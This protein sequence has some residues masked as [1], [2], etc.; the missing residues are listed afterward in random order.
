MT[1]FD[2]VFDVC[3]VSPNS[4]DRP[5]QAQ[6]SWTAVS[7][8][9]EH[10]RVHRHGW[11]TS[12]A[13][14]L[15]DALDSPNVPPTIVDL[16]LQSLPVGLRGAVERAMGRAG[17]ASLKHCAS[18]EGL[19]DEDISDIMA[20]QVEAAAAFERIAAR[21]CAGGVDAV[22]FFAI[23][24][25]KA[26]FDGKPDRGGI[27]DR[28]ATEA[29]AEEAAKQRYRYEL[30]RGID[31]RPPEVSVRAVI[32]WLFTHERVGDG[33]SLDIDG[34]ECWMDGLVTEESP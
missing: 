15:R 16:A 20:R 3:L 2:L 23:Q 29:D 7:L 28:Y 21:L 11:G 17:I 32:K 30:S 33:A 34:S 4:P 9:G 13:S 12:E 18:V 31:P 14:A 8:L 26:M 10:R 6:L 22:D 19:D 25:S 24:P 5:Y 27:D 1:E